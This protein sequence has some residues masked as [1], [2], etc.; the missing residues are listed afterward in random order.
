MRLIYLFSL[1]L[2][3]GMFVSQTYDFT[4]FRPFLI[5][6]TQIALGYIM[7][8]V[9]L[10]FWLDKSKV[11]S[12]LKDYL[13]AALAATAPWLLCFFYFRYFGHENSWEENLLLS[14]F[15]APTS[16]GILFTM[17]AAGGLGLTWVFRKVRILAI[18]D[19]VDTII[20]LVPLQFLFG[21][22]YSLIGVLIVI[23]FLLYFGW[24]FMHK[25]KLP[26]GRQ[27]IFGYSFVLAA[28]LQWLHLGF[29][30][31]MEILLPAFV[32]GTILI[33]P[34]AAPRYKHEHA[35]LEPLERPLRLFDHVVKLVFMFMV[36]LLLPKIVF[37]SLNPLIA[38]LHV[39][40]ITLLSN[41]G[42]CFPL[43]FYKNEVSFSQRAAVSV[44]MFPRGEVGAGI[45]VL[46]IG[47]GATGYATTIAA[48]SLALNLLLT[49]FFI[50]IVIKLT[51]KGVAT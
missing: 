1:S 3:T 18:L 48:L 37:G 22:N 35:Y 23:L 27:W 36:G 16:S 47:H 24:V 12:H 31:E 44:G 26:A 33:N 9:G 2:I 20:L 6:I 51:D 42:K 28:V 5:F 32:F 45:L 30:I 14:R 39:I 11:K 4:P 13:V 15:A 21:V 41:L 8:E 46:A 49:G 43:F 50:W 38:T 7:M 29:D 34:H 40:A 17:L 10:E 25:L 19:D